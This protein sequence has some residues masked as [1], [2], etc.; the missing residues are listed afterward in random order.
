MIDNS[1]RK[2]LKDSGFDQYWMAHIWS[3]FPNLPKETEVSL[4][5]K[6]GEERALDIINSCSTSKYV[7]RGLA[8]RKYV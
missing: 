4:M 7:V 8:F 3:Q 5:V 1:G 2:Y 6:E